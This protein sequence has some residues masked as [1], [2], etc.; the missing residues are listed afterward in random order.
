MTPVS[1]GELPDA[2]EMMRAPTPPPDA[3]VFQRKWN[4]SAVPLMPLPPPWIVQVPLP[5]SRTWPPAGVALPMSPEVQ[6]DAES[7]VHVTRVEVAWK[8]PTV[9]TL[10][11]T[12]SSPSPAPV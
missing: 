11:V 5:G 4:W 10:A 1:A 2:C 7:S 9:V 12:R 8:L 3:S 6:P